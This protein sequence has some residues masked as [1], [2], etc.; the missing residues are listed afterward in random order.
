MDIDELKLCCFR[1][2]GTRADTASLEESQH[3]CT[4]WRHTMDKVIFQYSQRYKTNLGSTAGIERT[5]SA[6]STIS[7]SPQKRESNSRP[8]GQSA[9]ALPAKVSNQQIQLKMI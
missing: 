9:T 3:L 5:H 6:A 2:V 7:S 8:L 4:P 1:T